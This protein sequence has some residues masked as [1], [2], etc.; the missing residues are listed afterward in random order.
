[1]VCADNCSIEHSQ[2][3]GTGAGG[4][5]YKGKAG[6]LCFKKSVA[7]K[8]Y[9]LQNSG[10]E[11]SFA[12]ESAAHYAIKKL[13][14]KYLAKTYT[15]DQSAQEGRMVMKLYEQDLFEYVLRAG[16]VEGLMRNIFSTIC[17]GVKVLHSNGI[18]HLDLKPENI[19]MKGNNPF[20]CDFGAIFMQPRSLHGAFTDCMAPSQ[21]FKGTLIYAPPELWHQKYFNPYCAD[22]Y[23][24]GVMLHTCLTGVFPYI[25][26]SRV[27]SLE[28]ARQ[29]ISGSAFDLISKML[30]QSPELRPTISEV[31][32]HP[33]CK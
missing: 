12:I 7:V 29:T 4:I 9:N 17:K 26:D 15:V 32:A 6:R 8:V 3:L 22:I 27:L 10:N 30:S 25:S 14:S 2:V 11:I 24:L 18:A 16:K 5:V 31:L 21:A 13:N 19:L 23:S 28:Y 1:M 20:I 33:W